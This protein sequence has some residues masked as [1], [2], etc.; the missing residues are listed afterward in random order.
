MAPREPAGSSTAE[1]VEQAALRL[2]AIR[3]FEGTGI[4][5]IADEAGITLGTLY[6]HMGT[7]EDLLDRLMHKSMLGLLGPGQEIVE[8]VEDPRECIVKLVDLHVRRHAE[9]NL[10]SIVGDA[11]IRSLTPARRRKAVALRD[12]Y[13]SLWE[14]TIEAGSRRGDFHVP[15]VKLA[16]LALLEMCS[17]VAY[18]YSPNGRLSLDAISK[19]FV[20]MSLNLLGVEPAARTTARR[21]P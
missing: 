17:G 15:D 9:D 11:E 8:A 19:A 16:T 12:S 21:R 1:R 2:F 20:E 4:R 7:K 3:G 14:S 13:E 10:L 6:H 5:S 18:W